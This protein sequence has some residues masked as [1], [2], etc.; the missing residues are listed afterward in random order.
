MR[1]ALLQ[2]A[3]VF[4]SYAE[5]HVAKGTSEGA[6]KAAYNRHHAQKCREAATPPVPS[7]SDEMP[8]W[9]ARNI[10]RVWGADCEL[11]GRGIYATIRWLASSLER[12]TRERDEA[13]LQ[14][15]SAS[16]M[17][18]G[19]VRNADEAR[20]EIGKASKLHTL[21]QWHEDDHSVLWWCFD[22]RGF[23]YEPPYVGTPLDSDWPGYH[24]HWTRITVVPRL[25]VRA[26]TEKEGANG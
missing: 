14:L 23:V 13:V 10:E 17:I 15:T 9:V 22:P 12:V 2:A 8:E 24:T 3:D 21:K 1:G 5:I 16:T 19:A 20:R 6:K 7:S 26:R 11:S 25:E 18:K 4:D